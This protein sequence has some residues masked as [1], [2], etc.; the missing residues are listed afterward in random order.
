[1]KINFL[2]NFFLLYLAVCPSGYA[3]TKDFQVLKNL[4][5]ERSYE[6][7]LYLP[8]YGF[9]GSK[10]DVLVHAPNAKKIIL[11]AS[12]SQGNSEYQNIDLRIA[13][14][15]IEAGVSYNPK[16]SFTIDLNPLSSKNPLVKAFDY[17]GNNP[18]NLFFEA[19]IVY[20]QD[21]KEVFKP[22]LLCGANASFSNN[23]QVEIKLA[24]KDGA[25][26]SS[27]ARNFLPG[28]MRAGS[29]NAVF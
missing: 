22:A 12:N 15:Y 3:K 11:L 24:P 23:N 20:D 17:S 18:N 29:G 7:K 13:E 27:M 19:I 4:I 1:M 9:L 21:G 2:I 25:S 6:P 28:L 8:N 5:E 16:A 14:N 10:I 26:V